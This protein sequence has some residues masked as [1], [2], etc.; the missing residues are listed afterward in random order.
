MPV[1]AA[2]STA[3]LFLMAAIANADDPLPPLFSRGKTAATL[4]P[5]L[6][7]SNRHPAALP[8]P[9]F[10]PIIG[11]LAHCW[12]A[13]G[14]HACRPGQRGT[15][16]RLP[17]ALPTGSASSCTRFYSVVWAKCCSWVSLSDPH[18][19]LRAS[20]EDGSPAVPQACDPAVSL[21]GTWSRWSR[22]KAEGFEVG[23][24]RG[25]TLSNNCVAHVLGSPPPC[26]PALQAI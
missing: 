8:T 19:L 21:A 7:P 24:W 5:C 12:F 10:W 16:T 25:H 3:A 26:P 18:L 20:E 14:A 9:V 11:P 1:P 15:A 6:A 22:G 17:T 13:A 2:L 4:C 23:A